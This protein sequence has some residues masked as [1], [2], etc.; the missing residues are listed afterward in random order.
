MTHVD[1][2]TLPSRARRRALRALTG[3]AASLQLPA[4]AQSDA[5]PSRPIRLVVPSSPGGAADLVGR[6]FARFLEQQRFS[7]IVDNRPGAGA[8]I[9]AEAVKAAPPDGYTF[10]VSGNS[11][12]AANPSLYAKLPYD[13]EKDFVEVGMFG[14]F[15]MIGIVRSDGPHKSL[16]QLLRFAKDNPDKLTFGY[17][18][19]S[20]LVPAELLKARAGIRVVGAPYKALSGVIQDLGGGV[21][22]FAFVDALS[23]TPALH[24]GKISA[25][26]VT[27]PARFAQMPAV[28]A[29]AETL[30]GFEVQGWLGLSAPKGTPDAIVTR[31]NALIRDA[32]NDTSVRDILERQGMTVRTLSPQEHSSYV[33]ADRARWA[34]WVR[35]AR[36]APM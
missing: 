24:S 21:I 8:I 11:T 31:V 15:P 32:Q 20:A 9:G 12:Q 2:R 19:S 13:P 36:I 1:T 14:Q 6:T 22:D 17:H 7:A 27:S 30:P 18:A 23:A 35:I 3:A 16:A 25:F 34:E 28:E 26:A 5:W 10:L 4:F 29:I 33:A